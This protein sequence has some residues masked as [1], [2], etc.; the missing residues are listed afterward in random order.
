MY[1]YCLSESLP[2]FKYIWNRTVPFP[3]YV[4]S[5]TSSGMKTWYGSLPMRPIHYCL[6]KSLFLL[7]F[8]G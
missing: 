1:F 3:F 6:R 4:G 5:F 7:H 8:G 2:I